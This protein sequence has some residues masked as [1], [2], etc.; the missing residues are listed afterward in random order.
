M[1]AEEERDM[2]QQKKKEAA[3]RVGGYQSV[4]DTPSVTYA[5]AK[6]NENDDTPHPSR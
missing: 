4:I 3:A 6:R 5:K 1:I 2:I